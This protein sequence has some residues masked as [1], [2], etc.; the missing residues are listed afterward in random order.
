[1]DG[2]RAD[3]VPIPIEPV[4]QIDAPAL[5]HPTPT[6]PIEVIEASDQ[7]DRPA[8]ADQRA[9]F[10]PDREPGW[11][12]R[13]AEMP[14]RIDL[15]EAYAAVR[16]RARSLR[17]RR[18]ISGVVAGLIM[19]SLIAI[20]GTYYVSSIPLPNALALPATTTVYYADGST[21]MARLGAQ[22]R[23]IIDARSLPGYVPHA[24]IAAEDP[25]FWLDS[26]TLISRQYARAA[27]DADVSS[28]SGKARLLIMSWKL[29]DQYDKQEILGFYLNTVY[30]GRGAYGIEAA[31]RAYFGKSAAELSVAEAVVLAGV[32]ESPGDGRFDPTIDPVRA[33]ARFDTI[34]ARMVGLGYL[35]RGAADRFTPPEVDRYDPYLFQS[36]LDRP[37]GLVVAQALAELRASPA[38]RDKPAGYLENGGFSIVTTVDS[39]AQAVLERTAD[40]TVPQSV[41]DGQPG[42]LQAAAV[43]VEPGTGRVLAYYGGHDGTGADYAGWYQ[44]ADGTPVGYGAH[45]PGQTFA[46]Y[47]LATALESGI[48][49]DSVWDSPPSKA[50]PASGRTASNPVRDYLGA[51]CQ[52]KCRL[53]EA[54]TASLNIPY[55]EL[56]ERLGADRVIDTARA[57]GI[58]DLWLTDPAGAQRRRIDLRDQTGSSLSP[59]P[60]G[61]E[62]VLGGYPVTVLD[63]ANTMATFAA[64]G[65]VAT[66]HF[67]QR[68]AR[69]GELAYLESLPA[70]SGSPVLGPDTVVALTRTLRQN[71]AGRLPDGRAT[72]TKTGVG[73]LR[74]SAVETAHAWIVGYTDELAMAVW[75][76]NEEIELPLRDATGA[77][78]SGAGLPAR[79]YRDFLTGMAG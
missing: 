45:P 72:A 33:R 62:V 55:F 75:I 66:A 79:I 64:G 25:A 52:P 34:V 69:N 31:S 2:G 15:S 65:N 61:S 49:P 7:L 37:T 35:E 36:G 14:I 50:F 68:V 60:V 24:V 8:P 47:A 46:V 59:S 28:Q 9:R 43:V 41:M 12:W 29:E 39:R 16:R 27:T 42:N 32:I 11:L 67:V 38:F 10:R 56:T 58:R 44:A 5:A 51:P 4:R 54:T 23:M 30:F 78:V 6:E 13:T 17:R 40:E 48:S 76:G 74:T 77:R 20:V 18:I 71:P 21:V 63:Q 53:A 57:V 19:A 26:A 1:M 22:N 73:P 70:A 3:R